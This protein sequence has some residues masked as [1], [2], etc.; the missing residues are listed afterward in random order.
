MGDWLGEANCLQE[1]G[2]LEEE[3]EKKL[4]FLQ[5]AQQFYVAIGSLYS[6]SRNLSLIACT[7]EAQGNLAAALASWT[8]SRDLAIEINHEPSQTLAQE[9]IDRLSAKEPD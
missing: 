2:N 9:G 5:E 6:Q 3:I 1:F 4:Q 8:A 7:Q